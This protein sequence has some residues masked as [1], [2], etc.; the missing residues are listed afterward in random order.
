MMTD[1]AVEYLLGDIVPQRIP[2][3]IGNK[4]YRLINTINGDFDALFN[5]GIYGS[6]KVEMG[7]K[8]TGKNIYLYVRDSDFVYQI[9]DPVDKLYFFTGWFLRMDNFDIFVNWILELVEAKT[10]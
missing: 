5:T 8:K 1:E 3:E 7:L 4:L 9:L 6:I 2:P 10:C